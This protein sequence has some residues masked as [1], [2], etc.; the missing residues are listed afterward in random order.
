MPWCRLCSKQQPSA[1]I[2]RGVCKDKTL[3]LKRREAMGYTH[4]EAQK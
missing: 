4:V 3:C 1:E 2:S